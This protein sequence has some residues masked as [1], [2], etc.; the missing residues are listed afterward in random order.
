[1][2]AYSSCLKRE[3]ANVGGE[4]RRNGPGKRE[5]GGEMEKRY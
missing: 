5:E 4:G 2:I 3:V 1:M